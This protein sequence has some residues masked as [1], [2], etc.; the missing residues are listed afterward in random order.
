VCKGEE[1]RVIRGEGAQTDKN[2]CRKV[3]LQNVLDNDIWHAFYQSNL[4]TLCYLSNR[5][6]LYEYPG[7]TACSLQLKRIVDKCS[8]MDG[9]YGKQISASTLEVYSQ[10][11][12][13]QANIASPRR[14]SSSL[15]FSLVS[16]NGTGKK[17]KFEFDKYICTV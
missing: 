17:L 16:N 12:P 3:P 2:T 14:Y 9:Q 6:K 4:S 13:G 10:C 8:Y 5:A 11:H 7:N 1:Y 15:Y